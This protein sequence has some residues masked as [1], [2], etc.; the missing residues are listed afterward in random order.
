MLNQY[1]ETAREWLTKNPSPESLEVA[2]SRLKDKVTD[3]VPSL[4]RKD[5]NAAIW[6]IEMRWREVLNYKSPAY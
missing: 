6:L 4:V 3:D 1:E 2:R 5:I